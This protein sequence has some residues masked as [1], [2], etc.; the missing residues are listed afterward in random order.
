MPYKFASQFCFF[1]YEH[2]PKTLTI[3]KTL[4]CALNG[5]SR[6]WVAPPISLNTCVG[7]QAGQDAHGSSFVSGHTLGALGGGRGQQEWTV[8]PR[9]PVLLSLRTTGNLLFISSSLRFSAKR[10]LSQCLSSLRC[11]LTLPT[12]SPLFLR[13]PEAP[14]GPRDPPETLG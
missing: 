1:H 11:P 12:P 5:R 13:V 4:T 10:R 9:A 14:L 8:S 6:L 2:F 3:F 7:L